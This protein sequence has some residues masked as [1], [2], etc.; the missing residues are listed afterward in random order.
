M[1]HSTVLISNPDADP[2]NI[3]PGEPGGGGGVAIFFFF[4]FLVLHIHVRA[5]RGRAPGDLYGKSAP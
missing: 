2:E 3:E 1:L 4:F 5:N